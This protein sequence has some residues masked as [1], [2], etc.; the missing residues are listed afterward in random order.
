MRHLCPR[1]SGTAFPRRPGNV[2]DPTGRLVSYSNGL[3]LFLTIF[4]VFTAPS[5][6]EEDE[7]GDREVVP[8]LA[9]A[10]AKGQ[11]NREHWNEKKE[12]AQEKRKRD[13]RYRRKEIK[14][15]AEDLQMT[16]TQD[17]TTG[18]VSEIAR[19]PSTPEEVVNSPPIRDMYYASPEDFDFALHRIWTLNPGD[20]RFL[21]TA[22]VM[23]EKPLGAREPYEE[24]DPFTGIGRTVFRDV[25]FAIPFALTNSTDI[26][27]RMGPRLWLVSENTRFT[28]EIGGLIAQRDVERSIFRELDSTAEI[29]GYV[30]HNPDGSTE[31]VGTLK[32]GE[33]RYGVGIFTLPDPEFDELTLVV[34]GL[35]NTY[36]YDRRQKRV[37]AVK[38][39]RPG[40]EFFPTH[41]PLKFVGKEWVWLWM[42]YEEIEVAQL[43]DFTFETPS[44]V[45]ED[46]KSLWAYQVTLMNHTDQTQKLRIR[47]F[48]TVVRARALGVEVEVEFLDD[49]KSTIHKS[50]VMEEMAQEF[51]GNRFDLGTLDPEQAKVFPVIFDKDDIDWDG[52]YRQ[53]EGGL[54]GDVSIGYGEEPLKLGLRS[55]MVDPEKL[56][57][58]KPRKL[59][60][61]QREQVRREILSS[62]GDAFMA[63]QGRSMITANVTAEAGLASGTFRIVRSHFRKGTIDSSW[64]KKWE[65]F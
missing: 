63:E 54:T 16:G 51:S 6:A 17:V 46:P 60:A 30:K 3:L 44:G 23:I 10:R 55:F 25:F 65:E 11:E 7:E 47:E 26:P 21:R 33:T 5:T 35:N 1:A 29:I 48:N 22:R 40:D 56:A 49:G 38:F 62:L 41:E 58:T 27:L 61:A 19:E 18:D 53:V 50:R 32:S 45:R 34:D 14:Q 64:I 4:L 24:R 57:R 59:S 2:V 43:Q 36:R 31:P 52:V 13:V 42:W 39:S 28:P 12:K 20:F 8:V 9:R 37:L 15:E